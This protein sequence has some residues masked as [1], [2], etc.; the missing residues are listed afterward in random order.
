MGSVENPV[1]IGE[2]I[3]EG[4]QASLR[5][6]MQRQSRL[7]EQQNSALVLPLAFHEEDQIKAKKPLQAGASALELHFLG[8]P[9]IGY[10]Y[11][12][13]TAICFKAE[14]V[15]SLLPPVSELFRQDRAGGLKKYRTLPI[16]QRDFTDLFRGRFALVIA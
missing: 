8:A 9:V 2:I 12:E 11:A 1:E 5:Q 3:E 4:G 16:F 7:I 13:M 14:F 6:R 15:I 10:P